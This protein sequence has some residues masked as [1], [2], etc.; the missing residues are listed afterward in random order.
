MLAAFVKVADCLSVSRAAAELDIGKSLVS[1]RVAQL[2]QALG[3]TLFSRSTRRIVLTPAGEA[4]AGFAR[5]ALAE[6]GGGE[7]R[8]RALRSELSGGIRITAAVSWGQ[9]VLAKA[10]P[11]FLRLH[12]GIA[13]ELQLTDRVMDIAYERIDLALRWSSGPAH[14]LAAVP[15]ASVGWT[16]VAAPAYLAAAG[17]PATPQDLPGHAGLCYWREASDDVWTLTSAA[18]TA[19]VRVHGRYHVD[20]PEAVVD[21]A[22]AGLGVA[23]L[24]DYLCQDALDD[25]RLQRVLPG[26]TPVTKFGTQITAVATPERLR[27]PRCRVLL[28]FL[29]ERL[30]PVAA[31]G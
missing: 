31:A 13:I 5:R 1:K 27:L 23:L 11:E 26:W 20:N 30:G 21:A 24:P 3:A 10:L 4:Y 12:P 29:R 18:S 28:S 19:K 6:I 16:L 17:V 14:D 9:R 7:E 2:E 22:L 8:L 25:G 15:V